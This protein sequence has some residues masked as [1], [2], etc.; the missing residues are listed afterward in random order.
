MVQLCC[1]GMNIEGGYKTDLCLKAEVMCYGAVTK[2][3][4]I[5]Y[6]DMYGVCVRYATFVLGELSLFSVH[7]GLY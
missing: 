6:N 5:V 4:P 7:T 3:T 1:G 2:Y